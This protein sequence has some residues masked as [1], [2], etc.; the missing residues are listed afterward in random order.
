MANCKELA[1]GNGVGRSKRWEWGGKQSDSFLS[2]L[3]CIVCLE[4]H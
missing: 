3:G 1:N 2:K 4:S